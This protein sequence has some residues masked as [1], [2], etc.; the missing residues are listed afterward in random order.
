MSLI[1]LRCRPCH[2]VADLVFV[3]IP[4]FEKVSTAMGSTAMGSTAMGS[5]AMGSAATTAGGNGLDGDRC[6]VDELDGNVKSD[7]E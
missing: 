2:G 7:F 4:T 5:T 6:D 1:R 3:K